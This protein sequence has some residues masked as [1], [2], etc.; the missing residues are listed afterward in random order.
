MRYAAY[1]RRVDTADRRREAQSFRS[2]RLLAALP[3]DRREALAPFLELVPLRLGAALTS[4]AAARL[5][6]LPH[7]QHHFVA[8]CARKRRV[9]RDRGHRERRRGGNFALHGGRD[10]AGPR[11]RAKRGSAYRLKAAVIQKEFARVRRDAACAAALHPGRDHPDVADRGV[12]SPSFGGPAA[13]PLAAPEPGP[14]GA[15]TSSR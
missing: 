13:M 10:H 2:N 15:P 7:R 12:Q 14:V 6:L 5:C 4:R 1:H 9:C 3:A 11:G 8:L